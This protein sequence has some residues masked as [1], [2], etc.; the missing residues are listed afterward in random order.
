[1]MRSHVKRSAIVIG[2]AFW[3]LVTVGLFSLLAYGKPW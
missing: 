2:W 1:M 3:V